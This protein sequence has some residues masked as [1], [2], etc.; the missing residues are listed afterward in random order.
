MLRGF[1]SRSAPAAGH[2]TRT[3]SHSSASSGNDGLGSRVRRHPLA[4]TLCTVADAAVAGPL[5]DRRRSDPN[6]G[7][8]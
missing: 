1:A 3:R 6:H 2:G 8:A 4:H 5:P 7:P